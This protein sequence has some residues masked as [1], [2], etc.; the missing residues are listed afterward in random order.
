MKQQFVSQQQQVLDS[1]APKQLVSA[2]AGSGKTTVMIQK[3]TNLLLN[4]LVKPDELLVVTFTELASTEMKERL[5]KNLTEELLTANSE[6]KERIQLILD[7][8]QTASVDTIDGF[9]SKMI[10]KHFYQ[11]GLDPEIKIIS[12]LS[13]Q[14]YINRALDLA[15]NQF[16]QQKENELII[17]C[18]IFEKNARSLEGL[19]NNLLSAFN[20]CV[21]QKDYDKFL[22]NILNEYNGESSKSCIYLNSYICKRIKKLLTPISRLVPH[23]SDYEKLSIMLKGY[24]THLMKVEE[25]KSLAENVEI[26]LNCPKINFASCERIAKGDINYEQIKNGIS[27]I[28]TCID[29]MGFFKHLKNNEYVKTISAHLNSFLELLKLFIA[30]YA[31]LKHDNNVIDFS[32]LERMMLDILDVPEILEN[33]HNNYKYIFVDE[34]QDINPMQNELIEKLLSKSSNLFLV[35]DV[36]QSI[37]GFRQSTPEL[38]VAEY[39]NYKSNPQV[40]T[41]FDMNINFRSSPKILKFNNEIFSNLMTEEKADIDYANTSQFEPKREDFPLGEDV[42]ILIANTDNNIPKP[43]VS[44]VYSVKNHQELPQSITA[45]ELEANI[46]LNKIKSLVGTEFYDAGLKK[47][48]TLKYSDIAILSRNLTKKT[49]NLANL[50]QINNI[51]INIKKRTSLK[52]CE[53]LAQMLSILK[54]L[55]YTA[56]DV[57]YAYFFTSPLVGVEYN[58]LMNIYI[59]KKQNLYNNLTTYLTQHN[60]NTAIKIRKGFKLCEQLR[61]VSSTLNNVELIQELLY[62]Y[63]LRQYIITSANGNEQLKPLDEFINS[64]SNE[65]KNLSI[66][67]FIDLLQQNMASNNEILTR[68]GMDSVTIQTIHASKGLEYPIVI[69]FNSGEEFKYVRESKEL[70]FDL[71]LGIGMQYYDLLQR[72]RYESPTRY[73][74]TL[75]NKEKAYKEEL[76]LLYVATTRA[77]NKLIIT[78]SCSE[79]KMKENSLALTNYLNLILSVYYDKIN[80]Q[81]LLDEYNFAN[82][83]ISIKS[84]L[85]QFDFCGEKP[86]LLLSSKDKIDKNINFKYN[87]AQETQLSIKNNVTALSRTL[88]ED[89]N[90]APIRLNTTENLNAT[91]D[92]LAS[93][94]TM[95]HAEL[96][97]I[98]Y[99]KPYN[100]EPAESVDENLIKNAYIKISPLAKSCIKQYNEKQFMMYV[101]YKDIYLDSDIDTKV[102]V[103]GVVDLILELD[104]H[105][106]LVDYKYSHSHMEK[107]K[108]KYSTQLK[109]YKMAIEKAFKK[110][111]TNAYIYSI[112]NSE[113]GEPA[114]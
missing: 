69:L 34:Y 41:S 79:N 16:G 94:G 73:A 104:D 30:N 17:L 99:A 10:R 61:V 33:F 13:Q 42:E 55:N 106:I 19:K 14:Y 18:D 75:K 20:Y 43:A 86:K 49:Q 26:L 59:D 78:G 81:P 46:V 29:G 103:Q 12:A 57:D 56:E 45:E 80:T 74:I 85:E 111:V 71:D 89:Y 72:K 102:L 84:K 51:P 52:D 31:N 64:L 68:D 25:G 53:P 93:I 15:I 6:Q 91:V 100:Y 101:P 77:K 22:N 28:K 82:C 97:S 110:P 7:G 50:L 3:I 48:R 113:L 109:L 90:I 40:G 54:I 87:Y 36:K 105:I 37:Y 5:V 95:Y 65:E 2:S 62:K 88:N 27:N 92:D 23:F 108:Q 1:V 98:N 76:R 11:A 114:I 39:K 67:K 4:D 47:N 38:F 60:D 83:T 44:G 58:E 96:A 66:S 9:C 35:G 21:C 107:L 8:I 24:T 112:K 32:D 63:H 70:Q